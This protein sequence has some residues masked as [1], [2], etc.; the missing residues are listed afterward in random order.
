MFLPKTNLSFGRACP[1]EPSKHTLL[2]VHSLFTRRKLIG[3]ENVGCVPIIDVIYGK[4]TKSLKYRWLAYLLEHIPIWQ[5]WMI[6]PMHSRPK[7][8]EDKRSMS[9]ASIPVLACKVV[10]IRKRR[11]MVTDNLGTLC[12]LKEPLNTQLNDLQANTKLAMCLQAPN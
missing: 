1:K 6:N 12:E 10:E 3:K 11:V 7:W 2:Q 4:Q 9:S 5:R 8:R